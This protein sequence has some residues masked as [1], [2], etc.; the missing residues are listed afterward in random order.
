MEVTHIMR[1]LAC[2]PFLPNSAALLAPC[3][4]PPRLLGPPRPGDLARG[5][6]IASWRRCRV[7]PRPPW[8]SEQARL[9]GAPGEHSEMLLLGAGVVTEPQR[10]APALASSSGRGLSRAVV[11]EPLY[12]HPH[13]RASCQEEGGR[14]EQLGGRLNCS[15]PSS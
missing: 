6:T 4:P 3:S 7:R 8:G 12:P 1:R 11:G 14:G 9:A 15:G 13:V 10:G 2:T 5:V